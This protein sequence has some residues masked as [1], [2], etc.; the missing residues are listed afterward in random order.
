MTVAPANYYGPGN[1]PPVTEAQLRE[2]IA[3]WSALFDPPR[4]L[5]K[6][7]GEATDLHKNRTR[8]YLTAFCSA[9]NDRA[10]VRRYWERAA[11]RVMSTSRFFPSP[12]DV[13]EAAKQIHAERADG[14]GFGVAINDNGQRPDVVCSRCGADGSSGYRFFKCETA[15]CE[16]R[17]CDPCDAQ[18]D[19]KCAKCEGVTR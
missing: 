16:S 3:Q 12:A 4:V 5:A 19:G 2:A 17:Q 10:Q 1:G 8:A 14:T 7:D 15:G 13:A 6:R 9:L 11:K 18:H